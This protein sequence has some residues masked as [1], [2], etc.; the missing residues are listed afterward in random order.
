MLSVFAHGSLFGERFGD[1]PPWVL[2]L[3]GWGRSSADFRRVLGPGASGAP[4]R[5][6]GPAVPGRPGG[7]GM[8]GG[9]GGPLDAIALDLP[10]F[11]AGPPPDEAWGSRQYAEAA[12][13]V[14]D[15]MAPRVVVLGHSFGGKVAVHLGALAPERVAALVLTGVP[16]LRPPVSQRRGPA[17]YRLIRSAHRLGLIGDARM[18]RARRTHGSSD[19]RAATGV[20]RDVLVRSVNEDYH[21]VITRLACPVELVWGEEDT[22]VPVAMAARA[23]SQFRNAKLTILPGIGHLTPTEAP[24]E[25]RGALVRQHP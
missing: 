24:D 14:L 23:A 17:A 12:A 8:P 18:E 6:D 9:P 11:G 20:M 13:A 3:H 25:L 19:Y 1:G 4:G 15:E 21:D 16:L 7:P 2:A 22:V 10:G 5:P